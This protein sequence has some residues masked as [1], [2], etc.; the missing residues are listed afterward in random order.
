MQTRTWTLKLADGRSYEGLS[1]EDATIALTR[2][3]HGIEPV[4]ERKAA[5]DE[6]KLPL[7]A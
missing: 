6:H 7:A 5:I 3:I 1:Q 2:L 4:A